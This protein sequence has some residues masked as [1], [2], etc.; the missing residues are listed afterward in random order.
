MHPDAVLHMHDPE[1]ARHWWEA[2][3]YVE[4][5]HGRAGRPADQV[6]HNIRVIRHHLGAIMHRTRIRLQEEGAWKNLDDPRWPANYTGYDPN[7]LYKSG[8]YPPVLMVMGPDNLSREE[9][10]KP[11]R[12]RLSKE[13][14]AWCETPAGRASIPVG[15]DHFKELIARAEEASAEVRRS[16]LDLDMALLCEDLASRDPERWDA[17]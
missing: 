4:S 16:K 6:E 17:S 1:Q 3:Q 11:T 8:A 12:L 5:V 9:L 10:D 15:V 14:A 2:L 7:H 13:L